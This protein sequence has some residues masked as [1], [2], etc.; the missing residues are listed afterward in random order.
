MRAA[1]AANRIPMTIGQWLRLDTDITCY[2]FSEHN[3]TMG[4]DPW[5]IV[6]P[7]QATRRPTYAYIGSH[8]YHH[9]T[10]IYVSINDLCGRQIIRKTH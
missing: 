1:V 9:D 4:L 10:V 5:T 6:E 2:F 7:D 8:L 3:D